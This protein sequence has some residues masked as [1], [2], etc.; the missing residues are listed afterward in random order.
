MSRDCFMALPRGAMGLSAVSDCDISGSY[1][2]TTFV[3]LD[4]NYANSDDTGESTNL[5]L[6]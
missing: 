5:N 1:S 6:A 4:V 3:Y 2:P